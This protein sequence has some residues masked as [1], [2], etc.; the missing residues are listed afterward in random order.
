M[1]GEQARVVAAQERA[2]A[3][4][5]LISLAA[6]GLPDTP[7]GQSMDGGLAQAAGARPC[8]SVLGERGGVPAFGIREVALG[9]GLGVEDYVR[10]LAGGPL[11]GEERFELAGRAAVV[12]VRQTQ[13]DK[14]RVPTP[15]VRVERWGGFG[16]GLQALAPLHP[17]REGVY[18]VQASGRRPI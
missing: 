15:L 3:R 4:H 11:A 14:R 5:T 16:P 9:R 7:D 12:N 1:P 8:W 2:G 17:G 18:A 10:D 13:R 6:R